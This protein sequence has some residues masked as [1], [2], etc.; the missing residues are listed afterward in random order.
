MSGHPGTMDL[1]VWTFQKIATKFGENVFRT[2]KQYIKLK[3]KLTSLGIRKRHLTECKTNQVYP[4]DFRRRY[5]TTK[6]FKNLLNNNKVKS[7]EFKSLNF[8]LRDT[9]VLISKLKRD[10]DRY[11]N[12][13]NR[14]LPL[15]CL[16]FLHNNERYKIINV[17]AQLFFSI[18]NLMSTF[19]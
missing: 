5:L 8:I 4:L 16:Q 19:T 13:L 17:E 18:L 11:Y 2:V 9:S 6:K 12:F 14:H 10:I 1:T 15:S 7:C 3:I